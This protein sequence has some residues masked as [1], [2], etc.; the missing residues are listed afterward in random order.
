MAGFVTSAAI[1]EEVPAEFRQYVPNP[2]PPEVADHVAA[3]TLFGKPSDQ[4]I[5][6]HRR[7]ANSDRP[8][9]CGQDPR[10]VCSR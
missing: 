4:F 5:A 1:P 7:A 6:G 3:V 2:M 9:V 10:V 8:A